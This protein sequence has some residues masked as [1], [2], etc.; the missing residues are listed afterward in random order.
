[1]PF[2]TVTYLLPVCDNCGQTP[3]DFDLDDGQFTSRAAAV[4]HLGRFGWEFPDPAGPNL[5]SLVTC[6]ACRLDAP[7]VTLPPE[8]SAFFAGYREG[9]SDA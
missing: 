9:L 2:E 3:S 1:M 8:A 5:P 4:E 6:P 7:L